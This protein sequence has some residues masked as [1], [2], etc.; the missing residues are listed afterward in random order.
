MEIKFYGAFVASTCT[1][2][3]RRLL[4][5]VAMPVP[6][7]STEPGWGAPDT[8]VDFHTGAIHYP[9]PA[10]FDDWCPLF[11]E[12]FGF[13][14]DALKK[15]EEQRRAVA[16]ASDDLRGVMDENL[17]R[18]L[19]ETCEVLCTDHH[20][21]EGAFHRWKGRTLRATWNERP[22][23]ADVQDRINAKASSLEVMADHH[24]FHKRKHELH[25]PNPSFRDDLAPLPDLQ[26][27]RRRPREPG[28][29][30]RRGSWLPDPIG[31]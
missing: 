26:R 5:G 20:S 6:H 12:D 8:L 16:K 17:C 31:R 24:A 4:D 22:V 30:R 3:T 29:R 9:D 21:L 1:P 14:Y 23:H 28:I 25:R 11:R 2:S 10:P 27:S 15:S 19:I 7:R 18:R 13:V